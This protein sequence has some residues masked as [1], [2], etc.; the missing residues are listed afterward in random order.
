[1]HAEPTQR[2]EALD[3][4]AQLVGRDPVDLLAHR[5]V[6]RRFLHWRQRRGGEGIERARAGHARPPLKRAKNFSASASKTR[7]AARALP[8]RTWLK[9]PAIRQ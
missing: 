9:R 3:E 1:M 8:A 6:L 2:L 7:A 4:A 5:F